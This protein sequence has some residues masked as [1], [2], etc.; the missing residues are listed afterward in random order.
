[1]ADE[2]IKGLGTLAVG[3]IVWFTVAAWFRT[4]GFEGR[5]LTGPTPD[6]VGMYGDALLVIGDAALYFALIGAL[7]FWVL[8]PAAREGRHAYERYRNENAD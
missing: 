2:F 1:M 4:P 3:G 8:I 7:T 5:Q 6:D